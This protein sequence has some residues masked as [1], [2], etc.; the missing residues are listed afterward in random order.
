MTPYFY[1]KNQIF[2]GGD[3]FLER[4]LQ[5]IDDSKDLSEVSRIQKRSVKKSIEYYVTISNDRN[6]AISK[7]YRSGGYTMKEIGLFFG[8]GYS[9]VSRIVKNSKFKTRDTLFLG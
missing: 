4:G 3:K 7:A 1:V 2:L 6:Q 9:M 5:L 8:L